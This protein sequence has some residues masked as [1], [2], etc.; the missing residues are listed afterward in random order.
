MTTPKQTTEDTLFELI[1]VVEKL[2]ERVDKLE[3]SS[4]RKASK[5]F[6]EHTERV[7]VKDTTTGKLYVSKSAAGK[8][9]AA[10]AGTEPTDHFAWYKLTKKFPDRMVDATPEEKAK[11][12]AEAAAQLERD[13]VAA[14]AELD[15]KAKA[16]SK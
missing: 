6:G 14:Q 2:S 13:R 15:A 16:D 12:E 1:G 5:K 10:E 9:L 11:V 4:V 3:K 8:D 7:A